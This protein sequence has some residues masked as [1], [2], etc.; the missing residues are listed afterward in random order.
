[1]QVPDVPR[2]FVCLGQAWLHYQAA[3]SLHPRDGRAS[4]QA[5][6]LLS[7]QLGPDRHALALWYGVRA[8]GAV[9]WRGQETAIR[10]LSILVV[11]V[12]RA[13][14]A[15]RHVAEDVASVLPL[16]TASLMRP[17]A[18]ASV[19]TD[20]AHRPGAAPTDAG[21]A[22]AAQAPRAPPLSP[23]DPLGLG[24]A[25]TINA[26]PPAMGLVDLRESHAALDAAWC[27][28]TAAL[29]SRL[30][31]SLAWALCH[32]ALRESAAALQLPDDK[33]PALTGVLARSS[34]GAGNTAER[35][36]P[37][38]APTAFDLGRG[39]VPH[40]MLAVFAHWDASGGFA[41]A[42]APRPLNRGAA[43]SGASGSARAEA[44]FAARAGR[45]VTGDT[46]ALRAVAACAVLH[47]AAQ[48]C[49]A[50]FDRG[51]PPRPSGSPLAP[52]LHALLRYI[53]LRADDLLPSSLAPAPGASGGSA[54]WWVVCDE[55]AVRY[56]VE[57]WGALAGAL[58]RALSLR[59]MVAS[60]GS[61]AAI[62]GDGDAG[63]G[64]GWAGTP[65]GVALQHF[66]PLRRGPLSAAAVEVLVRQRGAGSE[67]RAVRQRRVSSIL[68]MAAR[69]GQA[70]AG[71]LR[72]VG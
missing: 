14:P 71:F 21:H 62:L 55:A 52:A 11:D 37:D 68:A 16:D 47:L 35:G 24:S 6:A 32:A 61:L 27:G 59:G 69:V 56:L 18:S 28:F 67:S 70:L 25:A 4:M 17:A 64:V 48:A 42:V 1:M 50:V 15:V 8:V 65:E 49:G 5:A 34:E 60:M 3:A 30:P 33:L 22:P 26:P 12:V 53:A 46:A 13:N 2:R 19:A 54:P 72:R 20:A 9:A 23:V 36:P 7:R 41:A 38:V 29:W 51:R 57:A 63:V 10:N 44:L 31:P 45:W 66:G 43:S 58:F 40:A 39:L